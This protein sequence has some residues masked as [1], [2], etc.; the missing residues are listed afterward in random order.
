[1]LCGNVRALYFGDMENATGKISDTVFVD[2]GLIERTVVL[3]KV[4]FFDWLIEVIVKRLFP[5][6]NGIHPQ[7]QPFKRSWRTVHRGFLSP[8]GHIANFSILFGH[9]VPN[10]NC[11]D[12]ISAFLATQAD[13]LNFQREST[14]N[15]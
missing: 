5:C 12:R 6:P 9:I 8:R 10:T 13:G 11:R 3:G 14:G 15:H 4:I 2:Y 7:A 1:V